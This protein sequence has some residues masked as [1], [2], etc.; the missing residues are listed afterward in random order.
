MITRKILEVNLKKKKKSLITAGI[1][2][3]YVKLVQNLLAA[4]AIIVPY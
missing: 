3:V 2:D 4:M 1:R